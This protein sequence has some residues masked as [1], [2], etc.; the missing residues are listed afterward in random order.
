MTPLLSPGG[1][2]G[3]DRATRA[4]MIEA[5]EHIERTARIVDYGCH[6]LYDEDHPVVQGR[7]AAARALRWLAEAQIA[8]D[9]APRSAA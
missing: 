4:E 7:R 6:R 2:I 5:A 9:L 8:T 1:G 3:P